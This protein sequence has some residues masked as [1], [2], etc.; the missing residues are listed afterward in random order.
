MLGMRR[1]TLMR[2]ID[3][4]LVKQAILEAERQTSGEIRVAVSPLFWGSVHRA[5]EK[6]FSQLGMT[7]TKERNAILF[8]V[9]PA[10][11]RFTVLGDVGIH[12][13]VGQEFWEQIVDA[14]AEKFRTGD[15]TGG[16]IHGIQEAG[17]QLS[18]HFPCEREGRDNQ[19]SDD[20]DFG[21][22]S[23]Q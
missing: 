11:R 18:R 20:V 12:E 1:K 13:K 16:L 8:F 6:A 3:N 15:F 9:V 4:E 14:V 19:L 5:A 22:P 21:G 7:S 23:P 10:R 2:Q 17:R